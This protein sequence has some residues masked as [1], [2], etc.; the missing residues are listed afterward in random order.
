MVR[1]AEKL[2]ELVLM[3]IIEKA[4]ELLKSA[5]KI[6]DSSASK[7]LFIKT[8]QPELKVDYLKQ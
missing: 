6:L 3:Q 1:T 5:E 7:K 8:L 4:K 2:F